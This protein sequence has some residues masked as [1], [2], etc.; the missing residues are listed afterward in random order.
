MPPPVTAPTHPPPSESTTTTRPPPP[1][2]QQLPPP[3]PPPP[4]PPSG[5]ESEVP[6][7]KRKLEEEGF[8]RSPYYTIR[9]TVANLRG[10]F[11][12]VC[13]GTD[14]EKKD[15]AAEILNARAPDDKRADKVLS[16][17]KSLGPTTSLSGNFV[18]S[19]G[20]G[21]PLKPDNSDTTVHGLPVK[22]KNRAGPSKITGYTKQQGGLPQG[23]YVI[24]GSPVAWNFLIWRG[25]KAVYYGLTKAEWLARQSAK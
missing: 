11:L 6:P 1:P 9:E 3:P 13:Q 2:Q 10:R 12:Q 19:T 7:K 23:S 21:V 20:G 16:E 5:V 18:H 17:E 22:T 4:P 15:V 8:Q 25:S 24:G 14:S